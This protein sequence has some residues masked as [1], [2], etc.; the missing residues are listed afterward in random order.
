MHI[1]KILNPFYPKKF[2][3]IKKSNLWSPRVPHWWAN[4]F[5]TLNITVP[6]FVLRSMQMFG[7][8][9]MIWPIRK[10][11]LCS[12]T[13]KCR[14]AA[15]IT[16]STQPHMQQ[17]KGE[18]RKWCA[19]QNEHRA[20]GTQSSIHQQVCRTQFW[21]KTGKSQILKVF[22][23]FNLKNL[24]I[25]LKISNFAIFTNFLKYIYHF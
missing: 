22:V 16:T 24:K 9:G 7:K 23:K 15:A 2:P 19:D 25:Y 10:K 17:H 6:R 14:S 4:P 21:G 3:H 13:K 1:S 12:G 11:V 8:Y 5:F 20:R 18:N